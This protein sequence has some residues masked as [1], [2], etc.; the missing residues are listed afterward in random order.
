MAWS[1]V[2]PDAG[3]LVVGELGLYVDEPHRL[4]NLDGRR[5]RSADEARIFSRLTG[6]LRKYAT[7]PGSGFR[8]AAL[9]GHDRP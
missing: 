3:M 6:M 9:S 2:L 4:S 5:R 8:G 7:R 1:D